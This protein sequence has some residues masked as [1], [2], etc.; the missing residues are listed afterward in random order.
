MQIDGAVERGLLSRF[1]L[2]N[3]HAVY[4]INGECWYKQG[5]AADR[6]G[7]AAD[8]QGGWVSSGESR[9]C[10]VP[11]GVQVLMTDRATAGQL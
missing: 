6:Q 9:T 8:G 3:L 10:V 2:R 4:H 1:Q 11:G 5:T 7:V